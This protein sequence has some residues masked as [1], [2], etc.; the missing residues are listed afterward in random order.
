MTT[1]TSGAL[2]IGKTTLEMAR[3]STLKLIQDIPADKCCHQPVPGSNHAVWVLGHM[4]CT[5]NYFL[6]SL[7]KKDS[8]IDERWSK[9]FGMGSEPMDN[10]KKY[11]P[12]DEI[13]A[14]ADEA[15]R[16]LLGWFESMDEQ[17]LL[18]P[19]SGELAAFAPNYAG[20]MCTLG[21]HEGLHA[22]QLSSMRR[23]LGLPRALEG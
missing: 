12:L 4:A 2:E 1:T 7:G 14:K 5:D 20:L 10:P 22:G 21:W 15:R 3:R 17:Q 18:S 8:L 6:T 11:P 9:L 19:L 13:K 23:S 16:A